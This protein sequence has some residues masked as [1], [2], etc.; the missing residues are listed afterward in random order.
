MKNRKNNTGKKGIPSGDVVIS[1]IL[2]TSS[3]QPKTIN[4]PTKRYNIKEWSFNSM[5]K[6]IFPVA[7]IFLFVVNCSAFATIKIVLRTTVSELG[8]TGRMSEPVVIMSA[9]TVTSSGTVVTSSGT[10][11]PKAGTVVPMSGTVV[12]MSGTVVP[13]SG[14]VV[15][16]LGT[17]VPKSG[18]V[19]PKSGTTVTSSLTTVPMSG[20]I[21]TM[22]GN[23][24][25]STFQKTCTLNINALTELPIEQ[26]EEYTVTDSGISQRYKLPLPQV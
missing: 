9:T 18:T 24:C 11:V 13:M 16:M 8:T 20:T 2:D 7:I 15:P 21:V 4:K 5:I 3:F 14:T 19:A 26:N 6:Y 23:Y 22:S 25:R 17:V 12:I 10:V 1:A